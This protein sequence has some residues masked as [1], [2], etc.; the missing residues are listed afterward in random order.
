MTVDGVHPVR[1][2]SPDDM[3]PL[4][5]LITQ[6]K[7]PFSG[8]IRQPETLILMLDLPALIHLVQQLSPD[9][10]MECDYVA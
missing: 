7:L 10:I 5:Y 9:L 2:V 8:A 6:L 3:I 1:T 4:P